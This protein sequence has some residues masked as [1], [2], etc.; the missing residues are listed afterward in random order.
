MNTKK[1]AI[2]VFD[3]GKT[4]KKLFLFDEEYRIVYE[5]TMQFSEVKDED[6]LLC[7]DFESLTAWI[8]EKYQKFLYSKEYD[9]KAVNFSTYGATLVH[10]N[11]TG[12]VVAPLYNYLK[13]YPYSL[14]DEFYQKYGGKQKLSV[15][16]SSP[17]MGNLNLGLQLYWLKYER[18]DIY[19]NIKTSVF[20]PQYLSSL[21][22]GILFSEISYLGAHSALWDYTKSCYHEWVHKEGIFSK[23][24]PIR[25]VTNP[26]LIPVENGKKISIGIGLHD[27]SSA[28]IPYMLSFKE[29][30]GVISTGT[31]CISLNPYNNKMPTMQELD[32]GC[33]SYL[34][35][36]GKPVRASMLFAGNDHSVQVKR[37]SSYFSISDNFYESISFDEDIMKEILKGGPSESL[38]DIAQEQS[39][40][41]SSSLFRHRDLSNFRS[42]EHAYHKLILDLVNQ[43]ISSTQHIIRNFPVDKL[44]VD[45]G[46]SKNVIYMKLLSKAFPGIEV[47]SA[48]M[49]QAT[50]LGSALIMHKYWNPNPLPNNLIE[51]KYYS[52][53]DDLKI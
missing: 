35:V 22:T 49:A 6:G 7:E 43:Q 2:A 31:W 13:P 52:S 20:F 4:N 34:T 50:A 32:S 27:S 1:Q 46:F 33:L 36:Y 30:F 25:S 26:V 3:I 38:S 42:A 37:I 41:I 9:L 45:G 18:P 8:K 39:D 47:F 14:E 44:F 21:F 23:L 53:F 24:P 40:G 5:E 16:T 48:S 11:A 15:E 51:M 19:K 17:P 28:L 12:E 29:P 10:L